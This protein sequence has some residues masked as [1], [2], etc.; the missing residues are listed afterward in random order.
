MAEAR[1]DNLLAVLRRERP[2]RPTLFEFFLNERLYAQLSGRPVDQQPDPWLG[3]WRWM[4]EAYYQAGYDYVTVIG[5]PFHFPIADQQRAASLSQNEGAVIRNRAEFEAY[6]WPD[7]ENHD[8]G[9][10]E[11]LGELLPPGMKLVLHGP[12]GVFENTTRLVGYENLCYLVA[13]DPALAGAI[14]DAVGE[15]LLR[16]YELGLAYDSVGAIIGNDDWGHK[17]QTALPPELMRRYVFP[18]HQRIVAAAHAVGKP[19]ILH[20]CGNRQEIME[21]IIEV[22]AYDGLHSYEDLILPVEEAYEQ[23][24]G[25]IAIIGGID[26]DFLCRSTP[27][28]IQA[29]CRAM[30]ERTAERGGYALGSGNSIPAYVPDASYLAMVGTVRDVAVANGG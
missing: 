24:A 8:Y 20:S 2:E 21:D 13:D 17:T 4:M 3:R 14:F 19:A 30:L 7:P 29:R 25:R 5:S 12:S 9:R 18:W 1:F 15:R 11:A 6:E 27:A 26:V 22:M 23:F 10:L 16:H 28:E